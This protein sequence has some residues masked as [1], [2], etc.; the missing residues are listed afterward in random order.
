M[1]HWAHML[2]PRCPQVYGSKE[3]L[4]RLS[5]ILD[6]AGDTSAASILS[7]RA[8]AWD[9]RLVRSLRVGDSVVVFGGY[10]T[11]PAWLAGHGEGYP[12]R[13]TR[14]IPGQNEQ[15]AAV[16]E[17]DRELVLEEGAGAALGHAVRGRWLVLELGHAG[18]D[19]STPTPRIHV[20]LCDF[21]PP[22]VRWQD[23]RQGVWV[24]SHATYRLIDQS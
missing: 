1:L 10:D 2:Y 13:V 22:A 18:T 3:H 11:E 23:R 24:E 7:D 15:P 17:L 19:W 16:V 5:G 9:T 20:E 6:T 14:F 21:P 12:G 4:H 8:N